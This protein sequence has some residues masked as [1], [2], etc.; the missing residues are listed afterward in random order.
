[1][2]NKK[3]TA[4]WKSSKKPRKQH[5]YVANAP[6]HIKQKLMRTHL[7]PALRAKYGKRNVQLRKGDKVKVLRGQFN[8][9]EGKV[10][11]INLKRSQVF[12]TGV[13][14]I[15]KDGTKFLA[16]LNPSNLMIT[17]LNLDDNLRKQKL[18]SNTS[19]N[20]KESKETKESP[21]KTQT[22]QKNTQKK[23]AGDKK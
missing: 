3:F 15:K 13:E 7:S 10:D 2:V 19:S 18:T 11:H 17:E 9:R 1:M 20:A 8:G 16:T 12:V 4:S 22:A 5:L 6:L 21:K 23:V 14:N